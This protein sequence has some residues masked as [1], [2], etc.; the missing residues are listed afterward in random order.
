MIFEKINSSEDIKKLNIEELEK[1]IL[2]VLPEGVAYYP[3]D[4]YT[5]K[6]VR[7]M[8]GEIIRE[9]ALLFFQ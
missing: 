3:T 4:E 1:E 6:S 7:F 9:K 2:D 5:D 8:C